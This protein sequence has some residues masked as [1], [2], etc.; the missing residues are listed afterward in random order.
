MR[1][2]IIAI[3]GGEV[4]SGETLSI[5]RRFVCQADV[6]CPKLLFIPTASNDSEDYVH[7]VEDEFGK[8]LGCSIDVLRLLSGDQSPTEIVRKLDEADL[9]Y[10]GGG[11][12]KFMLETWRR[13]GVDRE[14]RRLVAMGK[15]VSGV[16]AGAICWFRVGNSDWPQYEQIPHVKTARLECLGLVD[17]VL[18]PHAK[19]ED[20]RLADFRQM[21]AGEEGSG[22]ALDD[23]CAIQIRDDEY[24]LLASCPGVG[25]HLFHRR[26]GNIEQE[27]LRPCDEFR[28]LAEL[29][30]ASA[31]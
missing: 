25:A 19:N 13:H 27:F 5:D 26:A 9:I 24:R 17:L 15:P 14:L 16:S 20:F 6:A 23:C 2:S 21:M 10:V 8:R 30:A 29:H 18:C 22:M 11:N 28:P 3:G 12:T 31:G 7:G 1:R 4:R